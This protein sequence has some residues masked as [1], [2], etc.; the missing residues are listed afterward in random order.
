MRIIKQLRQITH[1]TVKLNVLP[2]IIEESSW[3]R[4]TLLGGIPNKANV[5]FTVGVINPSGNSKELRG[6]NQNYIVTGKITRWIGISNFEV[7]IASQIHSVLHFSLRVACM[8]CT[9]LFQAWFLAPGI[10]T[11]HDCPFYLNYLLFLISR[12]NNNIM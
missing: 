4:I 12:P 9:K 5:Y 6:R 8:I 2:Q 1:I 3:W 7:K 10:K 11:G